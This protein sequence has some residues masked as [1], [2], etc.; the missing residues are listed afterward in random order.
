ML[1]YVVMTYRMHICDMFDEIS[2]M[3]SRG[4]IK[5]LFNYLH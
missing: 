3:A 5:S 2:V 4:P 1:I